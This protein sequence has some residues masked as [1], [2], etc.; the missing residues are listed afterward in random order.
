MRCWKGARYSEIPKNYALINSKLQKSHSNASLISIEITLLKDKFCLQSHTVD[1][2]QRE[3]CC[4]DTFKLLLKTL[5]KK[6][7]TNKGEIRPCKSVR[8]CKNRK[9]SRECQARRREKSGSNSPPFQG[10]VQIPLF[11]GTIHSKM[12]GV[13]QRGR[14]GGMLKFRIDRRISKGVDRR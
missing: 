12:P 13:C 1:T 9:N 14:V 4:D 2:F 6:L 11:P 5:L 7:C 3:I 8:P 10:N